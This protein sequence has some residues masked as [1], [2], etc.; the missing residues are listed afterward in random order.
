MLGGCILV[1]ATRMGYY[2]NARRRVGCP[3]FW[4]SADQYSKKWMKP[5]HLGP[6]EEGPP[7]PK[8]KEPPRQEPLADEILTLAD[9]T[10]N[11]PLGQKGD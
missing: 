3:P 4:V 8:V 10:D 2:G 9:M 7:L 1:T 6:G 5:V 11:A